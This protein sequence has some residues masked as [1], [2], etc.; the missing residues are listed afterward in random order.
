[1][2]KSYIGYG[3]LRD[4]TVT[5]DYECTEEGEIWCDIQEI[6]IGGDSVNMLHYL[7]DQVIEGLTDQLI[8]IQKARD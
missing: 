7:S 4:L 6:F 2:F 3:D 8:H 5:Y 1:M